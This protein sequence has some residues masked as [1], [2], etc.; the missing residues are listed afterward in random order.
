MAEQLISD[1]GLIGRA[2]AA[3]TAAPA[4]RPA[5]PRRRRAVSLRYKLFLAL[6]LTTLLSYSAASWA[7][8]DR[9]EAGSRAQMLA[10]A[11]ATGKLAEALYEQRG[12]TLESAA[13]TVALSNEV[14]TATFYK[15]QGKLVEAL[16]PLERQLNVSN[17]T[18]TNMDGDVIV[19]SNDPPNWGDNISNRFTGVRAALVGTPS[20]GAEVEE[21]SGLI[22]RGSHPIRLGLL[23]IGVVTITER[24]TPEIVGKAEQAIGFQS[25]LFSFEGQ[26]S[27]V[28]A[29]I[30]GNVL[31]G[32][33]LPR[34]VVKQVLDQ[35]KEQNFLAEVS[36]RALG[37]Y[38]WPIYDADHTAVGAIA[39]VTSLSAIEEAQ[40]SV[41]R[42]FTFLGL[43]I[44]LADILIAWLLSRALIH[45]LRRLTLA[46]AQIAG[47]DYRQPVRVRT[48]DEIGTLGRA[49]DQM[50]ERVG[51]ANSALREQKAQSEA[52]RNV[53]NAVLD[54]T[55]DG[56]IMFDA[57]GK[58]VVAN[59]RWEELFGVPRWSVAGATAER[60]LG[61]IGP[62][63]ADPQR[64][65]ERLR[66][67][68][69]APDA[70]PEVPP[71]ARRDA[72]PW[73]MPER[74]VPTFEF[75]W[76][77]KRFLRCYTAPVRDPDGKSLGRLVV[78]QDITKERTSEE[79]KSALVS[80]VTHELRTPL[81]AIKGYARTLLIE[82][83]GWDEPTREE[84]LTTIAEES[85]KLG[86]LVDNLLETSQ[87]EAGVLQ[88]ARRPL[89]LAPLVERVAARHRAQDPSHPIAVELPPDLP[90]VDADPRR[91]E[92]VLHNLIENARKYSGAGYPIRVTATADGDHVRVTVADRGIG[93]APEHLDHIF[94][95]F[96][97]VDNSLVRRAGGTGLGLTICRG[98]VEAHSGRLWAESEPDYGSA[99]HFTVPVSTP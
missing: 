3:P 65:G 57:A 39:V 74:E 83:A 91:L 49:L 87:I 94:E 86:E 82:D 41:V 22:L 98:I 81:A 35:G 19:R 84:F 44:L 5:R 51:A 38:A 58:L 55:R 90:V 67:L 7:V 89:L 17:I 36:G 85:D 40:A 27:P 68:L 33:D 54:S 71:P 64:L 93:I 96:Y 1:S 59:E 45:P 56:I 75:L 73:E 78:F 76:P 43:A 70:D 60:V 42:L 97:R 31:V 32:P 66:A 77:Q 16:V 80:T 30:Q 24:I 34:A 28:L 53:V 92:Q 13:K 61:L 21:T 95:R 12:A 72:S 37:G 23:Q 79:L 47:G 26:G 14:I 99:F 11:R 15:D 88:V 18:I 50:R 63:A 69:A 10:Q 46:A 52:E 8:Y 6:L 62:L 2:V 48:N 29:D 9:I 25:S 4:T 20:W